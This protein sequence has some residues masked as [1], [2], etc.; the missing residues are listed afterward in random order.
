MNKVLR[1]FM[2]MSALCLGMI[3]LAGVAFA[4]KPDL[5]LVLKISDMKIPAGFIST[6]EK[7]E[8]GKTLYFDPRLS[9]ASSVSCNSC[10]NV[11]ASGDDSLKTSFGVFGQKGGRNSPTVWN[12]GFQSVQFWD[13]RANTLEDQAKGPITNPIE[14]GMK[15]HSVAIARLAKIDGYRSMFAKVYSQK[16]TANK[17]ITID[18]V[19][20]AIAAYERTLNA[21]NSPFDKFVAGDQDA[22]SSDAKKGF[23]NFQKIGCV[24]CHSGSAF[25][26]PSMPL[27]VGFYQKFPLIPD[28]EIEKK[29]GFS[30]DVGRQD[31][32]KQESDKNMWRVP[33]LRNVALT[34]PYFHSGAVNDLSEAVRV[35]GKV[36]LG[37]DLSKS[38]VSSIVAFLSSLTGEFAKQEMPRLPPYVGSSFAE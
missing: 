5:S 10:H 28:A 20:D 37:K 30:K 26:G 11:M 14:M 17:L 12:S 36:Q 31:V 1:R 23:Q 35:M 19:A 29:Y 21:L 18:R 32:T 7:I 24:S 38:E 15:D 16:I 2:E 22:I 8:L 6:P 4:E 9:S 13:G 3:L 25:N 27:G 34:A 33:T